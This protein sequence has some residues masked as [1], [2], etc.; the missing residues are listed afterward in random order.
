MTRPQKPDAKAQALRQSLTFNPRSQRVRDPLFLEEDFF[1]PRDLA[2][3]KYEMLRRVQK[4][5]AHVSQAAAAFGLSRPSFYKAQTDFA[6]GGLAGL[7]PRK[8][9]PK[10]RRKL[11]SEIM[12]FVAHTQLQEPALKTAALVQRIRDRF[13]LTVHRRSLERA[14]L[15]V[16]KNLARTRACRSALGPAVRS[17]TRTPDR[18]L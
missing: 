4:Q 3:V 5:D 13:A 17:R 18:T 1:D 8:R 16:K 6:Q 10:Q 15:A 9:G 11:N 2:Q 14:L 12:A 7:I